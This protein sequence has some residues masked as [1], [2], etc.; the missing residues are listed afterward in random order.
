LL[1]AAVALRTLKLASVFLKE[2]EIC[3]KMV[4]NTSLLGQANYQ[5]SRV[6]KFKTYVGQKEFFKKVLV[7]K[8]VRI[9]NLKNRL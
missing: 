7:V 9:E 5:E 6:S 4:C 3:Y 8:G 2:E 1:A